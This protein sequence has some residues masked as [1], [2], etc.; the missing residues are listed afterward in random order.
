VI[1]LRTIEKIRD[2]IVAVENPDKVILFGS[3][4]R[5]AAV[6]DSDL[7]IMIVK[8][9]RLPRPARASRIRRKLTDF[10]VPKDIVYYTPY[11]VEYWKDTPC[12][13][14]VSVI[15]EGKIIYEKKR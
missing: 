1:S 5:G 9:S 13:F 11:E 6:E 7:D 10:Q 2:I 4:A 12:S 3:Y 14:V 15:K 8:K